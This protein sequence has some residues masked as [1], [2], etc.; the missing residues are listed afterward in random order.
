MKPHG[1][2]NLNWHV[3]EILCTEVVGLTGA[4]QQKESV[5]ARLLVAHEDGHST[6]S[7]KGC[8][9]LPGIYCICKHIA[10]WVLV[11]AFNLSYPSGDL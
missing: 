11:K 7:P 3:I 10:F 6:S 9:T 4:G 5:S 8:S 1:M 2:M